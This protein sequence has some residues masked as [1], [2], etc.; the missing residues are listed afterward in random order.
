MLKTDKV[1][2]NIENQVA[3]ITLNRPDARNAMDIDIL[4][5]LP[6]ILKAQAVDPAVR[7]VVI[8]GA[9]DKAFSA[10]G[11]ISNFN[12]ND[13]VSS[14]RLSAD[15]APMLEQWSQASVL[16]REMP[17][18]TLAIINGVAAGA[19]MSLAL[20]CDFRLGCE[21]SRFITS[22]ARLA[23]SGDFGGSFLLTQ[24]VGTAKAR[25]LYFFST[26]V[27]ATEAK[28]LGL[29]NWLVDSSKLE[30]KCHELCEHLIALPSITARNIKANLN[31]SLTWDISQA[32]TIE[33]ERM[34]ETSMNPETV[35]AAMTFFNK[36]K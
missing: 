35:A 12:S 22:F 4:E 8:R 1:L 32:V 20:S 2:V 33:A 26:P 16:L 17:K 5:Q 11:D 24:V 13:Q 3:T 18:P 6:D 25:E 15:L 31:E 27:E 36:S 14:A 21:R 34:T 28:S 10:G 29:L 9:G 23:M 7:C 19:G 30:S